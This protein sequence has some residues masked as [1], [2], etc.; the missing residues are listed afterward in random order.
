VF[1]LRTCKNYILLNFEES[2][3]RSRAGFLIGVVVILL[4]AGLALASIIS[5]ANKAEMSRLEAKFR[6][7]QPITQADLQQVGALAAA[8]PGKID[9]E[10]FAVRAKH[11]QSRVQDRPRPHHGAL[12]IY[13]FTTTT[14]EWV[15]ISALGTPVTWADGDDENVGPFDMGM[16]FS[17]YG[18]DFTQMRICS[19]GWI[20]PTSANTNR[21]FDCPY[22]YNFAPTN[23]IFGLETDLDA[24]SGGTVY[25]YYDDA[26]SRFI[27]SWNEV[28]YWNQAGTSNTFEIIL[29]ATGSIVYQYQSLTATTIGQGI[30]IQNA[31]GTEGLDIYCDGT[32]T[33]TP[34]AETAIMIAQ[35]V[36]FPGPITGLAGSAEGHTV[37]LNWT[38]PTTDEQGNPIN[39]DSADVYMGGT[40]L[41]YA[42]G[43]ANAY[44]QDNAPDGA[45]M[46]TVHA[47]N[48]GWQG[49]G[50]TVMVVVGTPSYVS[51]FEL[52]DGMWVADPPNLGN[53]WQCGEPTSA[54]GPGAA[55]SGTRCWAIGLT[56]A[57]AVGEC[58]DMELNLGQVVS[59]DVATVEF[60]CWYN[61]ET[62][63]D[64][65]SFQASTDD[66]AT[67]QVMPSA[68]Y[69][70]QTTVNSTS[71]CANVL[72]QPNWS[73]TN[74]NWHHVA[75]DLG[76]LVGMTPRFRMS[77]SSDALSFTPA[78]FFFD[79]M[80]IWGLGAPEYG[81]VSGTVHLD[82][83]V[84][85]ITQVA[86]RANGIGAPMVHPAADGTYSMPTVQT[87]RRGISASLPGYVTTTRVDSLTSDG[88]SNYDLTIRREL[89]PVPTAFTAVL[90]D[91]QHGYVHVTWAQSPDP[92]VD[93]YHLFRKM[94]DDSVWVDTRTYLGR[95]TTAG[96]DTLTVGGVWQY[97][98]T[99]VDVNAS[100]PVVS[101]RPDSIE[102]MFGEIPPNTLRA[103]GRFDDHI[104]LSWFA[105]GVLPE[106][107][108]S[109]DNGVNEIPGL[110]W[111]G[112]TPQYGWMVAHFQSMD[113]TDITITRLKVFLTDSAM[114]GDPYQVGIF[115]DSSAGNGY[116]SH[117][118]LLVIDA[119]VEEPINA[120]KEFRL[121]PR[122]DIP[123][124]SFFVGIR[125]MTSN[126]ICLGGEMTSPFLTHTYFNDTWG[127]WW[128]TFE[129]SWMQTP[130]LRAV[131]IGDMGTTTPVTMTPA[132]RPNHNTTNLMPAEATRWLA[133]MTQP[134]SKPNPDLLTKAEMSYKANV[135]L[136]ETRRNADRMLAATNNYFQNT[137]ILTSRNG[138]E[139]SLDMMDYYIVYRNGDSLARVLPPATI[140]NDMVAEGI[141]YNY[142]IVA[143]YDAPVVGPYSVP[144][145]TV[146]AM[147]VMAPGAPA[148]VTGAALNSTQITISWTNPTGNADG[149][150]L[151]DL[152]G[153]QILR[154][155][156]LIGTV[157]A[158][159]HS[160]LDTPPRS[161][162]SYVWS[163]KALDEVPNVG[164]PTTWTGSVVEPWVEETFDWVEIRDV[165]TP[166]TLGDDV[167]TGPVD[168]GFPFTFYGTNY[169]QMFVAS[170]GY[171]SFTNLGTWSTYTCDSIPTVSTPNNALYP[172]WSDLN[173]TGGFNGF[174]QVYTYTDVANNRFVVEW[175][176]VAHYNGGGLYYTFEI[177]LKPNG[178]IYFEYRYLSPE[179]PTSS[180]QYEVGIENETGTQA[181]QLCRAAQTWPNPFGITTEVW[182]P[183]DS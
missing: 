109:H 39:V 171:A 130:M 22:P 167:M 169:E 162:M 64:P 154:N 68:E 4:L 92:L 48:E 121:T 135:S 150:P 101:Q 40:L 23:G 116:P 103:N 43:G 163:V 107:D 126:A 69:D 139:A 60:Y 81:A 157:G 80:I 2:S 159:V 182:C 45:L 87:G 82:G 106:V 17:L 33:F 26:N 59:S 119:T 84:G 20:S 91:A 35:P 149:T 55:N 153:F 32:G 158:N 28:P 115:P 179:Q 57:Y 66:G 37:T 138:G 89:P 14:Y 108:A 105:P 143:H 24:G 172:W 7:Q 124:G 34:G 11:Q 125:Q 114:V 127:S 133:A 13:E 88:F 96:N 131:V 181:I 180:P 10:K 75:V 30:G 77:F 79:D 145:N 141:T 99:A 174:G 46:F 104:H 6:S 175:D 3:M 53:G 44:V 9:V 120:W 8:H 148:T 178:G 21:D 74:T 16:T 152:A 98:L 70:Y 142:D 51:D 93:E 102:V 65:V 58:A 94:R 72:L 122:M 1:L 136:T 50:A 117:T 129:T 177:I 63:W 31:D 83:G 113:S 86:V 164:A 18:T 173:T 95:A 100:T 29:Y 5:P 118:P 161:N 47:I 62:E 36:G 49:P 71:I 85:D 111:R 123:R 112:W 165:G 78:G 41:G 42:V 137:E 146:S 73:G 38:M 170:N 90:A 12:D 151:V 134:G 54:V 160:Y 97:A 176:S 128:A 166:L 155:D 140:Y 110:G 52:D 61:L 147:A 168:I 183:R 156:T 25:Y 144:S 27:V 132:P 19:N 76:S 15:D 67:W 56:Q